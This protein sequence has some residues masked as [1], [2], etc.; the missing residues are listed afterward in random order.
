MSLSPVVS[1][2]FVPTVKS[3]VQGSNVAL[4]TVSATVLPAL[5][6]TAGTWLLTGSVDLRGA[7]VA[8]T[9]TINVTDGNLIQNYVTSLIVGEEKICSFSLAFVEAAP[10]NFTVTAVT[11]TGTATTG[12]VNRANQLT[13]VKLA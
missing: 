6:Y 3:S 2:G 9:I 8:D 4:S 5:A 7:S 12:G 11:S 13:A 1:P 10:G